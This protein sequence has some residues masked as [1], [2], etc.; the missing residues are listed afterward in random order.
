MIKELLKNDPCLEF[1]PPANTSG[2]GS[3]CERCKKSLPDLTKTSME[4]IARFHYGKKRCVLLTQDQ[5]DCLINLKRLKNVSIAASLFLGTTFI[6]PVSAQDN[7]SKKD[8]CLVTGIVMSV[9]K[10]IVPN[11][12]VKIYI[13]ETDTMYQTSTDEQG[14][15]QL[16]LP[17]RC[18]IN[19][20]NIEDLISEKTKN[21]N[22]LD[23]GEV[24]VPKGR[25]FPGYL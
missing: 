8:S 14:R 5:I 10:K 13:K 11:Q 16:Y 18:K 1:V 21:R 12:S 6:N 4:D 20:S 23:V 19:Y 25:T 15:F 22:I 2:E 7:N 17:K 9:D 3:F 24:K